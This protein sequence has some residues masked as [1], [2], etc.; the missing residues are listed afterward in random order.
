MKRLAG[1]ARTAPI[2]RRLL[3]DQTTPVGV[4]ARLSA[5]EDHAFL[6]ESVV[7]GER[8]AR[9]SFVGARPSAV[10]RARR[11]VATIERAGGTMEVISDCRD[12]LATLDGLV[13]QWQTP[14]HGAALPFSIPLPRFTG[15]AVG[16]A[17]YDTIRYYEQLAGRNAEASKWRNGETGDGSGGAMAEC[18]DG[19]PGP[20]DD[21]GLDDLL[22]G[23]Y[24]EMVI[25]DHANK[26]L[27]V[28]AHA[29]LDSGDLAVAHADACRRIDL[30]V[31]KLST[32]EAG[33][34]RQ[35][36]LE[37]RRAIDFES[38]FT[39]PSFE[40]AVLAAKEY[41]LAGDIF[42][43]VLSQRLRVRA[44]ADPFDVYRALRVVNPSPFM[45]YVKSPTCV[46][47]GASPEILCR[48]EDGV[49][50]N[51]PLAGTRRRG[52]TAEEDAALEREL[53]ADPKDRAE[54]I[55]LVD[56]GR[57]DVGRVA[58]PG[59]V[60]LSDV[61]S[62][63]RYSH[64]MHISSNVTGRLA[65]GRTAVDA[66]RAALPVGTVSGAPKIRAMQIID[67]LEP[68]RRG[69]YGG[70]VGYLDFSGNMDTCIALRTMVITPP[71]PS[72]DADQ[73]PVHQG[74]VCSDSQVGRSDWTYDIQ[75]G[76]GIVMDS[77]PAAEFEETMNKAKAMLA[78][79]GMV[80]NP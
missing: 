60:E 50:T 67:E 61:M 10:F 7:G 66:L 47:V 29:R 43:V 80:S 54:H 74:G 41:I 11:G 27:L 53:L 57:N 4:F 65:P 58:A 6:L 44:A 63:E 34:G 9:Y 78:A 79:V 23:I 20:V 1:R 24:D 72:H 18:E 39:R 28:V 64:V 5:G 37:T 12:P 26:T 62:V 35:F 30:V 45:F 73:R 16:F 52:A 55:M 75:A 59:S 2:V 36:D 77:D 13:R 31:E 22:F 21:R 71:D 8:I 17:G 40:A 14:P 42:Q 19:C 69:P 15:G 51:R 38:T 48:V 46:L 33:L 25:F 68:V 49:V 70:A 56:L 76:A 3:A 32:G